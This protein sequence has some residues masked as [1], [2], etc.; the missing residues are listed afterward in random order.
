MRSINYYMKWNVGFQQNY[1]KW[2][3]GLLVLLALII[4]NCIHYFI[5][6]EEN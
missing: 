1:D 3:H 4:I 2:V 5:K 6:W